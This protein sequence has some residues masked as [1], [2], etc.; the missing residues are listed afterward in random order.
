MTT[1]TTLAQK[2][3]KTRF[4]LALKAPN[5]AAGRR[6][7]DSN[8]AERP[9]SGFNGCHNERRSPVLGDSAREHPLVGAISHMSM[10][11]QHLITGG[12]LLA[13]VCGYALMPFIVVDRFILAAIGDV[14]QL[15]LCLIV[16]GIAVRNAI[17]HQRGARL[18]WALIAV[19]FVA[20]S[21]NQGAWLYYEV[22]LHK[23]V[24]EPF[25]GDVLLFFHIVPFMAALAVRP[26]R[27]GGLQRR[28]FAADAALILLWWMFLYVY[29]VI[30]SQYIRPDLATAS[31]FFNVLYMAE[32]ALWIVLV[33][34]AAARTSGPWRN[35]YAAFVAP[36]IIGIAASQEIDLAI[37]RNQY[38]TGSMYDVPFIIGM[39]ILIWSLLWASKQD[40]AETKA[41][42]HTGEGI[43]PY[44]ASAL[45]L[46]LAAF[47]WF[48]VAGHQNPQVS[49]FR[50]KVSLIAVVVLGGVGILRQ[51]L[52]DRERSR[53]YHEAQENFENLRRMQ[54]QVVRSEKMVAVGELVG[55]AAHE[56]NNPL[57]AILG[58]AEL[59]EF[60]HKGTQVSDYAQKIA[61]QAR[62][63]KDLVQNLIRFARPS[64]STKKLVD[65]NS[66]VQNMIQLRLM[67][68]MKGIDYK[69]ELEPSLPMV[70]GD[71][72]QLMDVCFHVLGNAA[73][74]LK[75]T[76]GGSIVIRTRAQNGL[77]RI[78]VVDDGPG[79][80]EPRRV[81]DP[82]YT[83]KA[84]GQGTG[85]GLSVCYG[86][87]RNHQGEIH[88]ENLEGGG[89]RFV[90]QLPAAP[91][92]ITSR[93]KPPIF[94]S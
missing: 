63:T 48:A 3:P 11:R 32:N 53:L 9:E 31:F 22:F 66:V 79:M 51:R 60:D 74:A 50:L 4:F 85:L 76:R 52:V 10:Q 13:M 72:S 94:K 12:A 92:A 8:V 55:G 29:T 6:P 43:A 57:T 89:A 61:Q 21:M 91:A 54:E 59:L 49:D 71:P 75:D 47:A 45:A 25:I 26:H 16:F 5:F 73:D 30:P 14:T 86:I 23:D 88:A 37:M 28:I 42:H 41:V 90:I 81:F 17:V 19:G 44:V 36:S 69:I 78:E 77:V 56:I 7:Y 34:V 62:R 15:A 58:Y 24:P 65:L 39:A 18:F 80:L 70:W 46:S 40:H 93:K 20:W 82:F 27:E 83:T 35:I 33:A 2:P 38:Y 67:D 87:I 1:I 64:D 68:S 84:V